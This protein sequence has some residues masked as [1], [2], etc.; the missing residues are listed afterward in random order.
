MNLVGKELCRHHYNNLIVNEKNRLVKVTKQQ[1][2]AHPKHEEYI[3]NNKKGRPRKNYL[4]KIPQRFQYI[5]DLPP[6]TLICNP[7]L[8]TMNYN[9]ENQ[10]SSNLNNT[11][12]SYTLR[13]DLL[14]SAKEFKKLEVAY[15]KVCK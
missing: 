8:N 11:E 2:C 6:D 1:Q 7:C 5:L 3:K 9:K 15:H 13:G 4:K 14:Y 10:R 12:H